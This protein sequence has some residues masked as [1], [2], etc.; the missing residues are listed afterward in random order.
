[1]E[2]LNSLFLPLLTGHLIADF[3][4]Q[5]EGWVEQ[6]KLHGWKSDKA[7][8]HAAISAFLSV[9]LTFQI[10]LWWYFPVIFITHYI[11][12]TCKSKFKDSIP[13]FLTDQSLHIGVLVVLSLMSGPVMAENMRN[14]WIFCAG[15]V[16][17]THPVGI[18]TGMFLKSVTQNGAVKKKLDASAWIGIIERILIVIFITTA[19]FQSIGFLVAAK[20]ILRF[21]DTRQEGTMKAEYFLLGTMISFSLAIFT[22][23]A[24]NRLII[25]PQP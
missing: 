4:L 6:K 14:F 10:R 3:W 9:F 20:S 15:F 23:L 16:L 25:S 19:Q 18:F 22:G 2:L 17:V 24:I 21:N 13:A 1:M 12:D 8:F 7:F 5:P 11:I